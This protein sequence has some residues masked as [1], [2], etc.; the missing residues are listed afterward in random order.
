MTPSAPNHTTTQPVTLVDVARQAGVSR[1]TVSLVLR[2]SPLV[3]EETRQ[4]V[5]TAIQELGYIYNRG[6]ARLRSQRSHT[7]GLVIT[8]IAN[9]FFAELTIGV[10][11]TL[12]QQGYVALLANTSDTATKQARFLATI[13]EH[14][15]DGLLLC[16]ARGTSVK[17]IKELSTHLPTALFTRSLPRLVVDYVGADNEN[18]AEMAVTHLIGLGHQRIAFVGGPR[19][20][21][22]RR[23]R[24]RG[25]RNGLVRHDLAVDKSLLVTTDVTRADGHRA[26]LP[27]LDLVDPPTAALCYNDV[28][29]FGV[30]LGLQAAGRKP[31]QD[32]AVI[33]FDD[34]AEA[35]LWQPALTT[36]AISPQ[37]IGAQ[38]AHRL[39]V[40]IEQ[41]TLEPQ[42][43]ILPATL[44][45]RQSCGAVRTA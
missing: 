9:P 25:Y 43:I 17:A 42:R 26:I 8:D 3:A 32:F 35:A 19:D 28:V 23:E 4:R 45:I 15:A 2:N 1:S 18:G 20:S 24:L 37:Q 41:P 27:L 33:G 40:R 5:L 22:A 36:V 31:G 44:V 34:V 11:A 13:Q 7:I 14:Q 30:M 21:S 38:A 16:P 29:A 12:E 39:L 6:A 10:E